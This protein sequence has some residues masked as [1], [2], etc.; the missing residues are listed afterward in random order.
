MSYIETAV[1]FLAQVLIVDSLYDVNIRDIKDQVKDRKISAAQAA[2][3][4][5]RQE[6]QWQNE[7]ETLRL[8]Q[9]RVLQ[10]LMEAH[11]DL[12]TEQDMLLTEINQKLSMVAEL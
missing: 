3:Q 10:L 5:R 8:E 2:A 6:Q 4:I 7:R 11:D 9:Q 12:L 1:G